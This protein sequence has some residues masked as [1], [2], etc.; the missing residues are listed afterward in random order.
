MIT[1]PTTL[2]RLARRWFRV[3]LLPAF[4][5]SL[6][7]AMWLAVSHQLDVER[8]SARREATDASQALARVLSEHVSH[9]LRQTDH[10]T[11]LFKLKY[12]ET[13][14]A[15]RLPEFSR[16]NGLLDS[17]LPAALDLPMAL[18]DR[19]G[20]L[21]DSANGNVPAEVAEL[22][23]FKG[24]AGDPIDVAL[25]ST[26]EADARTHKWHIQVARRLDD[27]HGKFD[28]VIVIMIDPM[29]FVDDYDRL[30]LADQDA[31]ALLTPDGALSVGRIGDQL[32]IEAHQRFDPAQGADSAPG[33]MA[34][35][36]PLDALARV[37]GASEMPRFGLSAVVGVTEHAALLRYQRQRVTYIYVASAATLLIGL[38][39]AL[40]MRQSGQLRASE[41]RL[42]TIADT[43]PAMVAYVDAHQIYRFHNLAYG[44]EFG[45]T[46]MAAPGRTIRDTMGEQRYRFLLPYIERALAGETLIFEEQN[47]QDG[48][49]RTQ[50]VTYIPQLGENGESVAGFHIMR[51]DITSQQR[52]KKR[53]LKLAQVDNLTGLTNRAGFLSKLDSAMREAATRDRLMA[54]M[55]MDLDRFKPVNDTHGHAVGDKLLKAVAGRL[56]HALR[57]T[58]MVARLGGD[59]F[60]IIMEGIGREDDATAAATKIVHA[61][62]EPFDLDGVTV[63]VS[64]S[65]GLTFYKDGPHDPDA[66]LKQAD[67]L[68][69]R[70]KRA[71]RDTCRAAA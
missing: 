21:R 19:R 11:Q 32:F 40:L 60:T 25:F 66:L 18:Y 24:L 65:I 41:A 5:L 67:M 49:E 4:A 14:G 28:G 68:L 44:R 43:M 2:Q 37:Y 33:E 8:H 70:A 6:L 29:L 1:A 59:E 62:R 51:Q 53:L 54:L 27:A 50:E 69:Y 7:A 55:Y 52:E 3:L 26:P 64:A 10:A 58:D 71:G 16:R 9:I 12:E 38:V 36:P 46:G 31:L 20:M 42:R 57:G 34:A 39:V 23:F 48:A 22:A 61:M 13:G 45:R 30:N 56:T 15:L 63:S 17:V 47:Q 35:A